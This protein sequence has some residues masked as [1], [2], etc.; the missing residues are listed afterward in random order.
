MISEG[1]CD[2]EDWSNN[3]E[4]SA[5]TQEQKSHFELNSNR[6]TIKNILQ[7]YCIFDQIYAAF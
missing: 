2:T 3:A 1:S 5:L 7:Y 4:H 6:K